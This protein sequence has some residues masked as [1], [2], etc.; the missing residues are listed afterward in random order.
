MTL[1]VWCP[2]RYLV[3]EQEGHE[4]GGLAQQSGE[5]R[6]KKV[7]YRYQESASLENCPNL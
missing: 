1:R 4:E 6:Q 2:Y 3:H 7:R 5:G